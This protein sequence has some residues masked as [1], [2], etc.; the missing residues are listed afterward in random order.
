MNKK[1]FIIFISFLL[2]FNFVS[3]ET[4]TFSSLGFARNGIWYSTDKFLE[5]EKI[6]IYSAVFNSSAYDLLGAVEF[7]DNGI[8]I[9]KS[10]FYVSGGGKLKEA[11]IEWTAI[12]GQHKITAKIKDAKIRMTDGQEEAVTLENNQTGVSDIFV[13]ALPPPPPPPLPSLPAP[14]EGKNITGDTATASNK[15]SSSTPI[16]SSLAGIASKS[17]SFAANSITYVLK[18][19]DK[20]ADSGKK[21]AEEKKEEIEQEIKE[22]PK[23]S[24]SAERPLKSSYLLALSAASLVFSNKILLYLLLAAG[25]YILIRISLKIAS[26]RKK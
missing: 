20:L 23:D 15:N 26:Q 22:I 16:I 1:I 3:A 13:E 12:K 9:G 2:I 7:F 4:K 17:A 19:T 21:I 24:K 14:A 5:E 6:T 18:K 10:G 11:G 25:L 8:S